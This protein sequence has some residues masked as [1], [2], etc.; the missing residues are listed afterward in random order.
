MGN[1]RATYSGQVRLPEKHLGTEQQKLLSLL[2][3][4]GRIR[5]HNKQQKERPYVIE[6]TSPS[7]TVNGLHHSV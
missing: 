7:R 5:D 6:E 2:S 1:D 4:L 3:L